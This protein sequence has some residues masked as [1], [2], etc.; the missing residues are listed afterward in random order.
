ME[1][2]KN[3][4]DFDDS[5]EN[6]AQEQNT[7]NNTNTSNNIQVELSSDIANPSTYIQT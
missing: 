7:N 2:A 6:L 4:S 5:Y 1:T 3:K